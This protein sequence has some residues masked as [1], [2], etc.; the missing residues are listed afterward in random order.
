M[1][2]KVSSNKNYSMTAHDTKSCFLLLLLYI[3]CLN[4][5]VQEELV[6]FLSYLTPYFVDAAYLSAAL[7]GLDVCLLV[8]LLQSHFVL[9]SVSIWSQ[10][11]TCSVISC[12]ITAAQ[13]L[14][15]GQAPPLQQGIC[16]PEQGLISSKVSLPRDSSSS[17]GWCWASCPA[18]ADWVTKAH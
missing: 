5:R 16:K 12:R 9:A 3:I 15:D 14:C 18:A 6:P 17:K 7:Q 4:R 10:Q 13:R 11:Y 2:L 1:I 8:H